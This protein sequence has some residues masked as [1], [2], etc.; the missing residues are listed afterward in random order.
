V[1]A[2]T[3]GTFHFVLRGGSDKVHVNEAPITL[4]RMSGL[5]TAPEATSKP[6][7]HSE[8][9][10]SAQPSFVVETIAGDKRSTDAFPGAR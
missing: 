3:Q 6:I 5:A 1:L 4:S 9:R 10:L 7:M 2:S 8:H